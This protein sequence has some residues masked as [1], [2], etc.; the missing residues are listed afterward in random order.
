VSA[1]HTDPVRHNAF[2]YMPYKAA[3]VILAV[4]QAAINLRVAPEVT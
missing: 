2:N 4:A 3:P 1:E